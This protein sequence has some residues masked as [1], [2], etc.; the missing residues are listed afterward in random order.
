MAG[1][2]FVSP[3]IAV[4]IGTDNTRVYVKDKG[5]VVNEPSVVITR[6][7]GPRNIVAVGDSAEEMIGRAGGNIR[8]IHPLRDGVI[9]D[10]EMAQIMI[11]YFVSKAIGTRRFV[12]PRVVVTMPGDVSKVE[13]RAVINTMEKIG[14]R[15]IFVVEQAFAAALGTGLPVY[16]LLWIS[17]VA[18]PRLRWFRWAA[19]CCPTRFASQATKLTK[20][21]RAF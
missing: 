7:E 5:I 17:A 1:F 12:R 3:D 10:Y 21:S 14:A 18:R 13:R 4:D 20:P 15:Q 8:I 2:Q 16:A 19:L 9:V 6:G 11:H